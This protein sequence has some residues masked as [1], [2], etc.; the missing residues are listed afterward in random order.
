MHLP[1]G[2]KLVKLARQAVN[3]YFT[4][5]ELKSLALEE[6]EFQE[7]KGVFVTILTTDNELRGCIGFPEPIYPLAEAVIKA[8]KHAA[9]SDPRFMPLKQEELDKVLFEV[10]ILT[11]PELIEVDKPSEYFKKIEIGKHGLIVEAES[12]KG[13]LLPNVA[14]EH[15]WNAEQFLNHVCLKAGLLEETWRE[16]FCKIYRFQTEMFKEKSPNG[17]VIKI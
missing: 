9:F 3:S 2:E 4:K 10:S 15:K 8:A 6:K 16:G 1:Q 13:L 12:F 14:L 5:Q 7:K 17:P 11:K